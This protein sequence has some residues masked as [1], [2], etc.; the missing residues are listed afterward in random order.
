MISSYPT[1]IINWH[2]SFEHSF[3]EVEN[4][5]EVIIQIRNK[6]AELN[7]HPAKKANIFIEPDESAPFETEFFKKL[8]IADSITFVQRASHPTENAITFFSPNYDIITMETGNLVDI[9]KKK[10]IIEAD[11]AKF[12][13]ELEFN[14]K[15]LENPSF[16]EKAPAHL[17]EEKQAKCKSFEDA[18]ADLEKQLFELAK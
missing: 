13:K 8:A 14:Q 16:V 2:D 6:R 12:K 17:I 18:L 10:A 7:A 4:A 9:D 15:T 5:K 1:S 11:I 3:E